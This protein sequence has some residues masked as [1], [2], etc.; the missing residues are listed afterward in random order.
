MTIASSKQSTL[1]V[2]DD[3]TPTETKTLNSSFNEQVQ[4]HLKEHRNTHKIQINTKN[5][6]EKVNLE[7]LELKIKK[8][9]NNDFEDYEII[10][11]VITKHFFMRTLDTNS[12]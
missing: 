4:F 9:N 11:N 1:Q 8:K 3:Q 10:D 2:F 7:A 5:I 6:N 12:R